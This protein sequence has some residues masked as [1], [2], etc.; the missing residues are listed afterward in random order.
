M[1]VLP[2]D[3]HN[4]V[5]A[6]RLASELRD[7]PEVKAWMKRL[8]KLMK[9]QPFP[10]QTWLFMQENQLHLMA[11]P[12][13]NGKFIV[14]PNALVGGMEPKASIDSVAIRGADGGAW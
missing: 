14:S 12:A 5:L 10:D 1:K 8:R 6:T 3:R 11:R 4:P 9:D 7:S 13:P 2:P